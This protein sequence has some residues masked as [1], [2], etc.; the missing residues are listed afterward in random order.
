MKCSVKDCDRK[1]YSRNVCSM[2]YKRLHRTGST[3]PINRSRGLTIEETF[4]HHMPGEPHQSEC[5]EWTKAK[6][7]DGYGVFWHDG[8][9]HRAARVSFEIHVRAL[10]DNEII[11]HRCDNPACVNPAHLRPGSFSDNS[12]DMMERGRCGT[13]KLTEEQVRDIRSST[14]SRQIDL[15]ERYG[16]H[17]DTIRRIRKRKTWT[18]LH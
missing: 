12:R 11:R 15:A 14:D 17:P 5:W 9:L 2:H 1:K 8:T 18:H 3:D 16:I 4:T 7:K 6:N 10:A 13:T